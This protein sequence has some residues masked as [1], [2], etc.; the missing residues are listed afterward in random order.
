MAVLDGEVPRQVVEVEQPPLSDQFLQDVLLLG[1]TDPVGCCDQFRE[2]DVVDRVDL[3]GAT[4][5]R[6]K[7]SRE[8]L[9]GHCH[10]V[11]LSASSMSCENHAFVA[12]VLHTVGADRELARDRSVQEGERVDGGLDSHSGIRLDVVVPADRGA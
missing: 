6:C 11:W 8:G 3:A 9:G 5:N 1:P 4:G 7:A 2:G 10:D 12:N